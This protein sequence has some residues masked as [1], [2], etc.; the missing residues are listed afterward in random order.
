MPQFILIKNFQQLQNYKNRNPP[1]IRL[2][3]NILHEYDF[4]TGERK[5]FDLLSDHAQ[6]CLVKLWALGSR[7]A[8]RIPYPNEPWLRAQIRVKAP[9][10]MDELIK[11][12]L[13]E[14]ADASATQAA[15]KHDACP[16]TDGETDPETDL[17]GDQA[18]E[19]AIEEEET[20]WLSVG[21]EEFWKLYPRKVAKTKAAKSWRTEVRKRD[22]PLIMADVERRIESADWRKEGGK[23]IPHP[24]TYLNQRRWEDQGIELPDAEDDFVPPSGPI[25]LE[26]A[27]ELF[28][29]DDEAA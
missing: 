26:R 19:Q 12:T 27:R 4:V 20:D 24:A 6:L 3:C 10:P 21:F 14:I 16:D 15:C 8:W 22:I 9:I 17:I 18:V 1:W 11:S 13:I 28:G 2:Y 25:S 5:K 23:F 29:D 7:F